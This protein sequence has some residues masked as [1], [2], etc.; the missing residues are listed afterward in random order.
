MRYLQCNDF[1]NLFN[2]FGF[3]GM[4]RGIGSGPEVVGTGDYSC[5]GPGGRCRGRG[6]TRDSGRG[7]GRG[8]ASGSVRCGEGDVGAGGG[9]GSRPCRCSGIVMGRDGENVSDRGSGLTPGVGSVWGER[10]WSWDWE[11]RLKDGVV[12]RAVSVMV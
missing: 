3:G 10:D 1:G 7:S 6:V 4:C 11:G 2:D 9:G 8:M 5:S 12:G